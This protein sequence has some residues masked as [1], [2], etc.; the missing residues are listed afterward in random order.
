MNSKN[1]L[2]KKVFIGLI[3]GIVSQMIMGGLFMSPLVQSI[4]YNPEFQSQLFLE[5]TPQRDLLPSV[6]GLII[7]SIVYGII[8]PRVFSVLPGEKWWQKGLWFG[9]FI[10]L[11]YWVPQEWFI[12]RTLL[13]EP[14]WL[15]LFELTLCLIGTFAQ[16]IVIAFLMKK[17]KIEL[18]QK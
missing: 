11:L 16:G 4:L 12:Y 15:N 8:Y 18:Q 3:A 2:F 7:F 1:S 5:I 10:W 9:F 14:L 13:H 17:F 6:L